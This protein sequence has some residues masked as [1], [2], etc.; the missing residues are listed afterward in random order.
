MEF[1][2]T[3]IP[4]AIPPESP[5][6]KAIHKRKKGEKEEVTS[7]KRARAVAS[8]K[9]QKD[10]NVSQS[11]SKKAIKTTHLGAEGPAIR[12]ARTKALHKSNFA[13]YCNNEESLYESYNLYSSKKKTIGEKAGELN[14]SLKEI[15]GK[16]LTKDSILHLSQSIVNFK[17]QE[18]A[19]AF[20]PLLQEGIGHFLTQAEQYA[21]FL[22]SDEK[23][24]GEALPILESIFHHA[25]DSK[26]LLLKIIGCCLATDK[27]AKGCKIY[28]RFLDAHKDNK[29]LFNETRILYADYCLRIGLWYDAYQLLSEAR[30]EAPLA[31]VQEEFLTTIKP[32]V[33]YFEKFRETPPPPQNPGEPPTVLSSNE[34]SGLIAIGGLLNKRYTK[35]PLTDEE[36]NSVVPLAEDFLYYSLGNLE[37]NKKLGQVSKLNPI[38]PYECTLLYD[39]SFK[40]AKLDECLI[41]VE[42][43]EKILEAL[44]E[45]IYKEFPLE[46]KLTA[47]EL[48]TIES[49]GNLA[50]PFQELFESLI[51][52]SS[53]YLTHLRN[54]AIHCEAL[55]TRLISIATQ[56]AQLRT[57]DLSFENLDKRVAFQGGKPLDWFTNLQRKALGTTAHAAI[58][59]IEDSKTSFSH[60][61]MSYQKNKAS[62]REMLTVDCYRIHINRLIDDKYRE[63]LEGI[64]QGLKSK[65]KITDPDTSL[66]E[67]LQRLY[68]GHVGYYTNKD[69]MEYI[70]IRNSTF[71]M[72]NSAIPLHTQISSLLSLGYLKNNLDEPLPMQGQMVCSGFA[73]RVITNSLIEVRDYLHEL[74]VDYRS[75]KKMIQNG[76]TEALLEKEP[77]LQIPIS[78]KE[79]LDRVNPPRLVQIFKSHNDSIQKIPSPTVFHQVANLPKGL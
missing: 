79:N 25:P 28:K 43:L 54:L 75:E 62:L 64:L 69:P 65:G 24:P 1:D 60:L 59:D 23:K 44:G 35:T 56:Q 61:Y 18:G 17:K 39:I 7:A 72:T 5:E 45:N 32:R 78:P 38:V 11:Q 2:P 41:G 13:K 33:E 77:A 47:S 74:I 58:F 22:V 37:L 50:L 29:E 16:P 40:T 36:R 51:I 4:G 30:K 31:E 55:F 8:E 21:D 70:N 49:I 76:T 12:S 67:W 3:L 53:P 63:D 57:G 52:I 9:I 26:T 34:A 15:L 14:S 68:S 10:E 46:E 19:D 20:L 6:A 73:M 66:E 48:K 27:L 42:K 71:M